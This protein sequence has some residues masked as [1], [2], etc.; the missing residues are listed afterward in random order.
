MN[1]PRVNSLKPLMDTRAPQPQQKAYDPWNSQPADFGANNGSDNPSVL[2]HTAMS[3][4]NYNLTE[5]IETL[6][7]IL[8][9]LEQQRD[10]TMS[11]MEDWGIT[12]DYPDDYNRWEDAIT[13]AIE[14]V[15]F[16][17]HSLKTAETMLKDL[18]KDARHE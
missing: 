7:E 3:M 2:G 17:L 18:Y 10:D 1:E 9:D 13:I 8:D 11:E 6:Q 12:V 15:E 4:E 5:K 16:A 14:D